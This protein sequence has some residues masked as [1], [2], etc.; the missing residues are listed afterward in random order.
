MLLVINT[1]SGCLAEIGDPFLS[2]N[3]RELYEFRFLGQVLVCAYNICS[4]G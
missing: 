2:E 3:P 4:Y 1:R